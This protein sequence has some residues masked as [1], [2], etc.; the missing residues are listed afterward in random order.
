[1]KILNL[2]FC[3]LNSLKGTW[4]IDFMDSAFADGIFAIVG[5]TGAGK[6]TILDAI[7]LAIY[8]QTPRISSISNTH[9]EL[10][11]VD[12][13]E[14]F[15]S[16]ELEIGQK[17]YRFYWGQRRANKKSGGKLQAIKREISEL[18]YPK[19]D[20]GT[21]LESKANLCERKAVEIMQMNFRQFTRS[22]ML[23]Q[24]DFCAFLKANA[25]EKGEILEQITGTTIYG[26]LSAKAY[27]IAK[28]KN[29]ELTVLQNKLTDSQI[30]GDEAFLALQQH[31]DEQQK[32][33]DNYKKTQQQLEH[34]IK[35]AEQKQ[36][37]EQ[38]IQTLT[39]TI[40]HSQQALD[41]FAPQAAVLDK[42][43]RAFELEH[44]YQL[45]TMLDLQVKE[46]EQ[47]LDE[48][49]KQLPVLTNQLK[50]SNNIAAQHSL[51][52]QQQKEHF[53][54]TLPLF[55][56]VR[57]LDESIRQ[58]TIHQQQLITKRNELLN[59]TDTLKNT[60]NQFNQEKSILDTQLTN[61]THKL[62]N[63]AHF[64]TLGND[65]EKIKL[66]I[67]QLT[68]NFLDI[69]NL[70]NSIH[71]YQDNLSSQQKIIA[72]KREKFKK[73]DQEIN[74]EKTQYLALLKE[75]QIALNI[76]AN[77]DFSETLFNSQELIIKENIYQYTNIQ[78]IAQLLLEQ[79]Q[80]LEKLSQELK[81]INTD[82]QH[83]NQQKNLIEETIQKN[84][85]LHHQENNSL[86]SLQQA[87]EFEQEIHL[88]KTQL[89]KLQDGNPCPLCGSTTHPYKKSNNYQ[90][91]NSDNIQQAILY[92]TKKTL[93]YQH[94]IQED[95]QKITG[96]DVTINH[97]K[98]KDAE[99]QNNIKQL[100]AKNKQ[101]IDK[102][103]VLNQ[104]IDIDHIQN[105]CHHSTVKDIEDFL[106]EIQKN[107]NQFNEQ[108]KQYQYYQP[109]ITNQNKKIKDLSNNLDIL[110]NEGLSIHHQLQI[111]TNQIT[112]A[113]QE[114][115]SLYNKT[116]S[117]INE[118]N[119][120]FTIYHQENINII[121]NDTINI[122][123]Y[124]L[125]KLTETHKNHHILID[126]SHEIN[127]K[128]NSLDIHINNTNT[129]LQEIS[130]HISI[131]TKELEDNNYQ[132]QEIKDKRK[133]LFE[134][135][136]T[137]K[138]EQLIRNTIDEL[139]KNYDSSINHLNTVKEQFIN[140]ENNINHI[141]STLQKTRQEFNIKYIKFNQLLN[142]KKF[143]HLQEFLSSRMNNHQRDKLNQEYNLISQ[144]LKN[145][146]HSLELYKK[147]LGDFIG[148]YPDILNIDLY[149]LDINKKNLQNNIDE[150]LEKIGK[151]KQIYIHADID[152][153]KHHELYQQIEQYKTENAIWF[154][155]DKLI[156]SADGKK[157]RNFVQGLTLDMVLFYANQV[158]HQMSERYILHHNH[159]NHKDLLQIDVIDTH[160]ANEK[161]STKNLS[162]GESFIVSLA[163]AMGL[164]MMN[165][166]KIDI[167]SLFL[168]EGFGT[169]DDEILD[170]ALLTLSL[171]NKNGKMIGI[172]SHVPALKERIH[173]KIIVK[174]HNNGSSVLTG[175]GVYKQ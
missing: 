10:M 48:L 64:D 54:Y 88:L 42:A 14:C 58:S 78:N 99:K 174:K 83:I 51:N 127:Q 47:N 98:Q 90:E 43:N 84:E 28:Q 79:Y 70:E 95:K 50:Q 110:K 146:Q 115:K 41:N 49:N 31:I 11:S 22:V 59:Q 4:Q 72:E 135:K 171:L 148:N 63:S 45:L 39:K 6:T 89:E 44:D 66:L 85:Q 142:E 140:I 137:E 156:G 24:G 126:Q 170:I 147:E 27:Q 96:L 161:R 175:A 158:L 116:T 138:E 3:N 37:Q 9:N 77:D 113:E 80:Q 132:I 155:L 20:G 139:Q 34:N 5:Q 12:T 19:Q 8:G 120:L 119:Q 160:Q 141:H 93:H 97:L 164:S 149:Q 124:I 15:A 81:K 109:I 105:I 104:S 1:M 94:I 162:G 91:K 30:M 25:N 112:Y 23:A 92:T 101:L 69:N 7:C 114:L 33:L 123:N 150:L 167:A 151:D 68:Q 40:Y 166:D 117:L 17:L 86:I 133:K 144:N 153:K 53:Q 46:H 76:D 159:N 108:N 18:Q 157:Y 134:D 67:S 87:Y 122:S 152:R 52:L 131:N 111:I 163:L 173:T 38:R 71:Q 13:G 21:I 145:Q 154:K 73:I 121:N 172:I 57:Q 56:K 169:L 36:Q 136:D 55:K 130:N 143:N 62:K 100:Q 60:L 118:I 103:I 74:Q 35:L 129:Q 32:Q 168:D 61:I 125:K 29:D 82:I 107:L 65:L 102:L 75:A 128:L 16:V 106:V 26:E 165:S 2:S